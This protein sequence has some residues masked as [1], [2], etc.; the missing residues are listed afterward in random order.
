MDFVVEFEVIV[1]V[2]K[3]RTHIKASSTLPKNLSRFTDLYHEKRK[4]VYRYTLNTSNLFAEDFFSSE[5]KGF[6]FEVVE[7]MKK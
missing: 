3:S 5:S 1:K 7:V 4:T 6:F 2:T